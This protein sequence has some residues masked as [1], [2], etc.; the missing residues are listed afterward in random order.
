VITTLIGRFSAVHDN[1]KRIA[2][3]ALTIG[4]LT[5]GAKVFVAAREMAIAWRYGVSATVDAYQMAI[6]ITTWLP[7]LINGVMTVV[8]V[9]RL[10]GLGSD[11]PDRRQFIN[12]SNGTILAIG[13]AVA[14]LTWLGAPV[15]ARLLASGFNPYTFH[16]TAAIASQISPIAL[17]MIVCG[18]L[19]AR[20][21]ARE[22]FGYS[23]TEAVPALIIALFLVVPL[24]LFG[25]LPLILGTLLG[26]FLQVLVLGRMALHGDPPIGAISVRHTS[27]EWRS[28]YG[29][30]SMM[31]LGQL[32]ITLATPIDQA[33]AARLGSGAVATLGYATRVIS[34]LT[35]F[36]AVV[37]ARALLPVLSSAVAAGNSS[38]GRRQALQWSAL[39][40]GVAAVG[41]T[42]LWIA[43]PLMVQMLFQRGAFD[44]AASEQVAHVLRFGLAQMPF[45]FSGIALVQWYAATNRFRAIL[46]ITAC[47]LAL[48]V[49]LN[50]LL[51]PRFGVA[52]IALATAGMYFLTSS[53]LAIGMRTSTSN[54]IPS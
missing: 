34:L 11:S 19:S 47:A 30:I 44:S 29:A 7:M 49:S 21:Q 39:L 23:A 36:G 15:A 17:C 45:Y 27:A 8:L 37:V 24:N 38:L 46:G 31:V 42:L 32:L 52:G 13:I 4:V 43:A 33:F 14:A 6:T 22:R 28:L 18:Y 51:A 2:S 26:Y 54:A 16:T 10:V 5:L 35:G 9:P 3:G 40:G 41:A 48:K 12:E 1:H 50:M 25:V 53:L 20:L